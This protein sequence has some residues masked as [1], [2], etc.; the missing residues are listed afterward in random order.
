[1]KHLGVAVAVVIILESAVH[2]Q[3]EPIELQR[4]D[5]IDG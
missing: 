3:Q 1:L 5:A 2:I 4:T